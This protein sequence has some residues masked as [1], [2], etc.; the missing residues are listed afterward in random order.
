[1]RERQRE[2]NTEL[3]QTIQYA[4]YIGCAQ[5]ALLYKS[6]RTDRSIDQYFNARKW[7]PT[8]TPKYIPSWNI[9]PTASRF[10][11][12]SGL[13][14]RS[15]PIRFSAAPIGSRL[16]QPIQPMLSL[17]FNSY[18]GARW[19]FIYLTLECP[20]K[21]VGFHMYKGLSLLSQQKCFHVT[22]RSDT[23]RCHIRVDI[24]VATNR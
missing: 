24:R 17:Y 20:N 15:K 4:L 13:T 1:M 5:R 22:H 3:I 7:S 19:A 2:Q 18:N 12:W 10:T 11:H 9:C 21:I 8:L 16:V 6:I 23:R 14:D